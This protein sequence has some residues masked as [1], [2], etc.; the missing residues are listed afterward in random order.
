MEAR[1]RSCFVFE[2][3]VCNVL[4]LFVRFKKSVMIR[5]WD[6]VGVLL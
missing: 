3:V 6:E 1:F 2:S 5:L 4:V